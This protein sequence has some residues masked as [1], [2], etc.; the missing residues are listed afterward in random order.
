M[1]NDLQSGKTPEVNDDKS[2]DNG[3]KVVPAYLLEPKIVT[4]ETAAD[5]YKDDKTLGPLTKA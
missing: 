5:I 1:V 3:N 4:K 2:Y